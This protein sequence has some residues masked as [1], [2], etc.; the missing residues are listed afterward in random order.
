MFPAIHR[1]LRLIQAEAAGQEAMAAVLTM[2]RR[3]QDERS[4]M[5]ARRLGA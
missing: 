3:H 5:F 2:K 4:D 1:M